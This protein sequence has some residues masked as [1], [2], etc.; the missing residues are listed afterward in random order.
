MKIRFFVNNRSTKVRIK[1]IHIYSVTLISGLKVVKFEFK[2]TLGKKH[3]L[4]TP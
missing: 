4:V 2:V 1:K 3:S